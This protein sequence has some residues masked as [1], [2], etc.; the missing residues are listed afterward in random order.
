MTPIIFLII[1]LI[2]IV[3][4]ISILIGEKVWRR[5][6]QQLEKEDREAK[7]WKFY[8]IFSAMLLLSTMGI[9]GWLLLSGRSISPIIFII[10]VIIIIVEFLSVL[11]F[12]AK[13]QQET[14]GRVS[15]K[16]I[17]YTLLAIIVILTTMVILWWLAM[18]EIK[19]SL[20]VFSILISIL[21]IEL[22]LIIIISLKLIIFNRN[23]EVREKVSNNWMFYTILISIILLTTVGV[24]EWIHLSKL[25]KL[26]IILS[27]FVLVLIVEFIF[28]IIFCLKLLIIDKQQELKR[29]ASRKR[30]FFTLLFCIF[31]LVIMGIM[32]WIIL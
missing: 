20:N 32:G 2:I 27:I 13:W 25:T 31:L 21:I 24:L 29:T 9:L 4:L 5:S 6:Y 17:F 8:T 22:V 11:I 3:G 1:T 18:L 10:I 23:Q 19:V 30:V 12:G 14:R 16:W 15:I 26:P 7:K 28:I